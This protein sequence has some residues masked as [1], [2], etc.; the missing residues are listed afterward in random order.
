MS[1]VRAVKEVADE[2][3]ALRPWTLVLVLGLS[4]TLGG[5]VATIPSALQGANWVTT[6]AFQDY[7]EKTAER[8]AVRDTDIALIRQQLET[9]NNQLKDLIES[10]VRYQDKMQAEVANLIRTV[11]GRLPARIT[12]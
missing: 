12:K 2:V 4:G 8:L 10:Q 3:G 6:G 1:P 7:K 9:L 5:G 11:D